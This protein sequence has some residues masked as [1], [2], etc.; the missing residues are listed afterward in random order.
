MI[1]SLIV[2]AII[3]VI[4][5]AITSKG[6]S[7]GWIANI[8]AGLV[9]SAVGQA[10]LGS[11]GPSLAGMALIPSII[12]AVIVVAVVSFFLGKTKD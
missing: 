6:K 8:L 2:G 4:A 11:W 1:W 3:G 5:G 10:L 9:G 12:G 7:M